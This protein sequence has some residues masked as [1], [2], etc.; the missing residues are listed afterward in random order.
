MVIM[1]NKDRL[2]EMETKVVQASQVLLDYGEILDN[3]ALTDQ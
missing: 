3:L 1:G 2:D